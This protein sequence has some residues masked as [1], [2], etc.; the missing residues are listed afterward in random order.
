M[1]SADRSGFLKA[2]GLLLSWAIVAFGQPAWSWPLSFLSSAIGYSLFWY[3]AF[4]MDRPFWT[5][6]LW[7]ASVQAIQISWLASS[8]YMGPGIFVVYLGL[9]TAIGLQFGWLT[10]LIEQP[11]KIFSCAM[12]A[13]FWVLMEWARL[14]PLTGFP[15]NPSGIALASNLYSLQFAA[16]VGIY[17]LSFWVI[18][19]NLLGFRALASPR[20]IGKWGAW[21]AAIGLPFAF[22]LGHL[23]N[24]EGE[25]KEGKEITVALVQTAMMPEEKDYTKAKANAY[26]P[27]IAQW[28]RIIGQLANTSKNRYDLIVLPE[29]ALPWVATKGA[30]PLEAIKQIWVEHFG[31]DSLSDLPPLGS[32][33][34]TSAGS[35]MWR[36][37]N[38]YWAQSLANHYHSEVIV[39]FL[40]SDEM[41]TYNA[42]FHF[43]PLGTEMVRYDKRIL[44]PIGEY[45]PLAGWRPLAEFIQDRFGIGDSFNEGTEA[46]VFEG[47]LPIGI[48]IC[49]EETYSHIPRET[50]LA[51]AE[52]FVTI[53]NDAWFPNTFL[54]SLHFEHG[55]I[56]AVE[57]GVCLFRSCNTGVTGAVDCFGRTIDCLVAS[58]HD[59]GVLELKT[60]IKSCPTLYT[61]W[62][63][64]PV[65]GLSAIGSVG[66][67]IG[68]FRKKKLP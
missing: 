33:I 40:A 30:Y 11:L 28:D 13:G 58:D 31:W 53:S 36:I 39:G 10:S 23:G 15:W 32:P 56:R 34:A 65:L 42:A 45:M 2:C 9:C 14:L 24:W 4:R 49:S 52:L 55:R 44:V 8:D 54:P 26:V 48:A 60:K 37:S 17:G 27:P 20:D 68:R 25:A 21:C 57:N 29:G 18:F 50:R 66:L 3:T 16:F 62:G 7:Y 64:W 1:D 38:A 19:A 67:A 22:G 51:G 59:P 47:A 41:K 6:T 12:I 61:I 5:A 63:D 35:G 46:K 43:R